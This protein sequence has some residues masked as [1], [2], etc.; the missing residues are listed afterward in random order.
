MGRGQGWA[1]SRRALPG[2]SCARGLSPTI[3]MK[4]HTCK[5]S[6]E[7]LSIF[8]RFQ[9][10]LM[11]IFAVHV[12]ENPSHHHTEVQK[13]EAEHMAAPTT[14]THTSR[15]SLAKHPGLFPS[16]GPCTAAPGGHQ[17]DKPA[18][19]PPGPEGHR[20]QIL[21]H[22]CRMFS[23]KQSYLITSKYLVSSPCLS[24]VVLQT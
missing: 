16:E 9:A 10:C 4:I 11:S 13:K 22:I 3:F 21:A 8:K 15:D 7:V 12:G 17:P 20:R 1:E 24:S 18:C 2:D 5:I 19:H 6:H 23:T 14:S